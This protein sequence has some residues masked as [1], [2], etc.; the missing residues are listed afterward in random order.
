M[1][2]PP[3]DAVERRQ[4]ESAACMKNDRAGCTKR[5]R[6]EVRLRTT[7]EEQ[8]DLLEAMIQ[9]EGV[10]VLR[11]LRGAVNALEGGDEE[12]ADEV[13]AFDDEVDER[14]LRDPRRGRAR[15]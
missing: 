1:A 7:F 13:I 8:L 5:R 2:D 6:V 12:L 15:R 10:L 3:E 4:R 14:Y 9:E 11:A